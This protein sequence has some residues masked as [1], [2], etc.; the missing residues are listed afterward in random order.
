M[1]SSNKYIMHTRGH[2]VKRTRT[3][4]V[5]LGIVSIAVILS[6]AWYFWPKHTP[7][8]AAHSGT[9]YVPTVAPAM[10]IAA[11]SSLTSL[12]TT[13]LNNRLAGI[14]ATGASWIRLDFDWSQIQSN[15]SSS[16]DWGQYDQVV[17][18]A[19]ANH[20]QVL[21]II[22][23]SPSWATSS[24][25]AGNKCPPADP[26]TYARF[27]ATLSNRYASKGLHYWEIWNEPNN[28]NFWQP[29]AN[30][31]S[32]VLLLQAAYNSIHAVD[33]HAYVITGGLS[34]QPDNATAMSPVKFLTAMYA[35]GAK[36]YF[37]AVSDHPYTFPLTPASNTDDAW[38][39][40]AA[41]KNSLR[42]VMVANSDGNKKIW[43]TEFGA[44][45]G[46]PGAV[47]TVTN[48]NLAAQPFVV[49]QGL[50]AKDLSDAIS[51]YRTYAW[52]GPFFY[53]T[54]QDSGTDISTNENFFGLISANGT[55]K[56][57]YEVFQQAASSYK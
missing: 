11:G 16:Y 9:S 45:T 39:Q 48:P 2:G 17:A 34:P 15:S 55:P 10:G 14:R 30:P 44:P 19:T 3:R 49:D 50:Q 57:A 38:T 26:A 51:A 18:A 52:V 21:G 1:K 35:D 22:D 5:V 41:P 46:G 25:C 54:Y 6:A 31:K 36:G 32:Y 40:M 43:I 12:S 4:F 29:G 20:L 8:Q 47:A 7:T 28:P 56:Q 13:A 23:Y 24:N 42:A 53:Y 33:S 27:A 37:D